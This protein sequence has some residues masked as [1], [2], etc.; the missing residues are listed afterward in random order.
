MNQ[1]TKEFLKEITVNSKQSD[2]ELSKKLNATQ[3]TISRLRKKLEKEGV[4]EGYTII[5]NLAKLDI[6]FVIFITLKWK[7]Y[8]NVKEL[9]EFNKFLKYDK[10][11]LF[12]APGEGFE[13]KTKIIMTFHK[14]Y[15]SYEL[16]LREMRAKWAEMLESMD[17]FLVSSDNIITNFDFNIINRIDE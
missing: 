3:P 8:T 10:R 17:S 16:F 14:N 1:L 6:E 7:D 11:V 2:R 12:S 15:K 5:P 9:E 4:I 13:D